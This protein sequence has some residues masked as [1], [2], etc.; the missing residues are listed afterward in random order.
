MKRPAYSRV[1]TN[2]CYNGAQEDLPTFLPM[3]ISSFCGSVAVRHAF[4]ALTGAI[5][6]TISTLS[7]GADD[8]SGSK[9]HPL[10]SRFTGANINSYS[11]SQFD[12]ATLPNQ[13][14][15]KE[16]DAK[17]LAVEGKITR[18]GYTIGGDKSTLEVERNYLEALQ[19]GGFQTLFH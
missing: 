1:Q 4:R 9:N 3:K 16:S 8:V 19:R 7:A 5:L 10:L 11:Q 13:A 12:E 6:L 17:T 18:V 14:I 2:R 15:E